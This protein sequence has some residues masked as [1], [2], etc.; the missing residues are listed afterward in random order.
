MYSGFATTTNVN[1]FEGS[2]QILHFEDSE[3]TYFLFCI[4]E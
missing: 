2:V 3:K 1:N 4:M